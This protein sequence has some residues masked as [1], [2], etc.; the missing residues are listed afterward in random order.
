MAKEEERHKG[1]LTPQKIISLVTRRQW[2]P[3]W[4]VTDELAPRLLSREAVDEDCANLDAGLL[5]DWRLPRPEPPINWRFIPTPVETEKNV[6]VVNS[7]FSHENVYSGREKFALNIV[8]MIAFVYKLLYV[9]ILN[10]VKYI[11]FLQ[12]FK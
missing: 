6:L 1:S 8:R 11:F 12:F 5:P 2:A 9:F 4:M 3:T 7:P 10:C